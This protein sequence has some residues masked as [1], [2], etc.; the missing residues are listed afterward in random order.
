MAQVSRRD[1]AAAAPPRPRDA[2]SLVLLREREGRHEVLLGRRRAGAR[3]MPGYYVFPGGVVEP[4]DTHARPATPLETAM[5]DRM[6]V[7]GRPARA[8]AL[9]MAAVRETFEETGLILGESGDVGPIAVE[10]W[11]RMR[12]GGLAPALARLGFVGRAI[13][14]TFRS[15]RFNA[16]FFVADAAFTRGDLQRGGELVDLRWVKLEATRDYPMADV[17]R[18]MLEHI[19][20][21][22]AAPPA[23]HPGHP[24]FTYRKRRRHVRYF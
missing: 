11:R 7:A 21:V 20:R 12:A 14:P 18:F 16:R 24:L 9:A 22:R 15:L 10:S 13:T 4:S 2:A 5:V 3:F 17:T 8:R 1:E 6:A 23:A 19:A